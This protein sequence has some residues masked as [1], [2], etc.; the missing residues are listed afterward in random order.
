M[1]HKGNRLIP[2]IV[3]AMTEKQVGQRHAAEAPA[4]VI[5]NGGEMGGNGLVGIHRLSIPEGL[6]LV[7]TPVTTWK[8]PHYS[9]RRLHSGHVTDCCQKPPSW[10]GTM[11]SGTI[12]PRSRTRGLS[13]SQTTKLAGNPMRNE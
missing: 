2:S 12:R 9:H 11:A 1:P 6:P 7:R 8:V 13:T 3:G 5:A 10:A 4:Q